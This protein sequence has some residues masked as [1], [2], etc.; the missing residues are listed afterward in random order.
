MKISILPNSAYLRIILTYVLFTAATIT[1]VLVFIYFSTVEVIE[2]EVAEVVATEIRS[3]EDE[4]RSGGLARLR[5]ALARRVDTADGDA[6]YLLTAPNNQRIVGNL[7]QWPPNIN[8]NGDWTIL[9]LYRTDT[10]SE[11]LVGAR[12]YSL[13]LGAK[14]LVGRDMRAR[15][16]FQETLT[17]AMAVAFFLVLILALLG[18]VIFSRLVLR[19][20]KSIDQTARFIMEGDISKRITV[21]EKNDEFDQLATT[22]NQM[23]AKV[24]DLI[25]ELRVATESMAH[26][27]RS[28]LTRLRGHL[29]QSH[30][31]LKDNKASS[32]NMEK[33]ITETDRILKDLNALLNISRLETGLTDAQKKELN[34]P[35]FLANIAELYVPLAEEN[36]MSLI[37]QIPEQELKIIANA[38]LLAQAISNL[39]ENAI[40]YAG[41]GAEIILSAHQNENI[42]T[43]SV[44]DN[45]PG[46][47]KENRE[48]ALQ[49][50]VRL[51]PERK[52]KGMGLGLYLVSVITKIH[53]FK[54]TLEDND[55]GLI[56]SI[57][58][59]NAEN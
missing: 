38:Q 21:T 50:F 11:V 18:G 35:D 19:R 40:K 1:G 34:L 44:S 3:L 10:Q 33:A 46:I 59:P 26:D 14:I 49:R 31:N 29:E 20:I 39:L 12:A 16:D 5:A 23:L 22:L 57:N 43:I 27:L 47:A 37:L 51:S 2:N 58:I 45:G 41:D 55:P 7:S 13:G 36:D 25:E 52:D 56:A 9:S 4:Y 54:F 8:T 32:E 48:K 42:T 17:E 53:N 28:P 15:R 30:A 24:E 6:I